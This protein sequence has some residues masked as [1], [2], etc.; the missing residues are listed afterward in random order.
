MFRERSL[1]DKFP[2]EK[3]GA[4]KL[5]AVLDFYEFLWNP[6]L[7]QWDMLLRKGEVREARK[8]LRRYLEERNKAKFAN[9]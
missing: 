8:Y 3:T 2:L 5:V 6:L 4:H 7:R 1:Q 9:I